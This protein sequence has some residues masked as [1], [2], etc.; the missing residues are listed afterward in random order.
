MYRKI[1]TLATTALFLTSA[2]TTLSSKDRE[3]LTQTQNTAEEA[4]IMS[5]EALVQAARAA[6]KAE[7]IFKQSQKK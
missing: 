6:E 4:K 3:L 5:Q 1:V 2:C 7:R